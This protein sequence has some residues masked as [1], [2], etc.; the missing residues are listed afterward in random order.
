MVIYTVRYRR[1]FTDD[2]LIG[3]RQSNNNYGFVRK[4]NEKLNEFDF[5]SRLE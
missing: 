1:L 2:H 4:S 5:K 3:S